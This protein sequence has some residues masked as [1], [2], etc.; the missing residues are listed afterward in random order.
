MRCTVPTA[1]GREQGCGSR[2]G[3]AGRLPWPHIAPARPP[4]K[5]CPF[6]WPRGLWGSAGAAGAAVQPCTCRSAQATTCSAAAVHVQKRWAGSQTLTPLFCGDIPADH[7]RRA[8]RAWRVHRRLLGAGCHL[9]ARAVGTPASGS[10][11]PP[12]G[13]A[14]NSVKNT[15]RDQK[16]AQNGLRLCPEC[17]V[18]SAPPPP[19]RTGS[20]ADGFTSP[21]SECVP[22]TVDRVLPGPHSLSMRTAVSLATLSIREERSSE[23]SRSPGGSKLAKREDRGHS[24][25]TG[26]SP[27]RGHN[28][29]TPR[30]GSIIFTS[31]VHS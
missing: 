9:V 21:C 25:H 24:G 30:P 16:E 7:R 17:P 12:A 2:G 8:E 13:L 18:R 20:N 15:R 26:N 31:P 10:P 19:C 4:E 27:C 22:R 14:K 28:T 1:P 29:G 6:L 11:P 23:G 5:G 3:T